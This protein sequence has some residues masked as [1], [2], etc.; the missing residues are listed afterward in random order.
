MHKATITQAGIL[1][2]FAVLAAGL[3]KQIADHGAST[4]AVI[5]VVAFTLTTGLYFAAQVGQAMRTTLYNCPTKGCTV[6][7]RARNTSP[8]ELDRLRTLATDHAKHGTTR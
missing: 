8:T 2:P 1:A 3:G 5:S 4:T 6:S 7:I